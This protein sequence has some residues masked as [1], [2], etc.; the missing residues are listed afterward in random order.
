MRKID[1]MYE[2]GDALDRYL[3][4]ND[5]KGD[6]YEDSYYCNHCKRWNCGLNTHTRSWKKNRKQQ[7]KAQR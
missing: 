1:Y 7:F 4:Y 2:P 5:W 3:R 6:R